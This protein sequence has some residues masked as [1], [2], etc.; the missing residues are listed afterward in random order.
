MS[1]IEPPKQ[2]SAPSFHTN[3]PRASRQALDAA[4]TAGLTPVVTED[5]KLRP[6]LSPMF[7]HIQMMDDYRELLRSSIA[8]MSWQEACRLA[9]EDL[10]NREEH[11]GNLIIWGYRA[12]RAEQDA[13]EQYEEMA[14]EFTT[15]ATVVNTLAFTARR[16]RRCVD[17]VPLRVVHDENAELYRQ[18]VLT[19]GDA[20]RRRTRPAADLLQRWFGSWFEWLTRKGIFIAEPGGKRSRYRADQLSIEDMEAMA[21]LLATAG[22]LASALVCHGISAVLA[23][24]RRGSGGRRPVLLDAWL[25]QQGRADEPQIGSTKLAQLLAKHGLTEPSET[26]PLIAGRLLKAASRHPEPVRLY[27]F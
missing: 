9:R 13:A 24:H 8:G 7:Q 16:D 20:F 3:P 12:L 10:N 26:V 22:E 23:A 21:R 11:K 4:I 14:K 27:H 15:A 25:L 18:H 6:L 2:P 17:G 5:G 1:D 19:F